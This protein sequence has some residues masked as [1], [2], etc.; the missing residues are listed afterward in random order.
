MRRMLT[1]IVL[2]TL[3]LAGAALSAQSAYGQSAQDFTDW[4]ASAG[5]VATGTLQG[6]AITL[7]GTNV[8]PFPSS[9]LDGS[10]LVFSGPNFTPPLP[11]SDAIQINGATGNAYTLQFATA[12]TDPVIHF[13]SIAS[14]IHFAPG[15]VVTRLSGDAEFSVAG[16]DVVG[17]PDPINPT[18]DA[19][20]SVR[21]SGTFTSIPVTTTFAF[22]D[23]IFV[24]VGAAPPAPPAPPPPPPPPAVAPDFTLAFGGGANEFSTLSVAP[25]G[26][27]SLPVIATRNATS[28]GTIALAVTGL[29]DGITA[30]FV[31]QALDGVSDTATLTISAPASSAGFLGTITITATPQTATAGPTA[32]SLNIDLLVQTALSARV[33]GIE[34]TQ[35]VQ[36]HNQ[37]R[38]TNYNGVSLVKHKKTVVRVFADLVGQAFRG[39]AANRPGMGMAL[40]GTDA[41]GRPL[42]GSPLF[43]EYAPSSQG[44][45]INDSGFSDA[46]RNSSTGPFTFVLPDGWTLGSLNLRASALAAA[47]DTLTTE[48][49]SRVGSVLC[50]QVACGARSAE[51][52]LNGVTFRDPPPAASISALHLLVA[53]HN[54]PGDTTGTVTSITSVTA[55]VEKVFEKLM[56]LSPVPFHF[57]DNRDFGSDWPRYRALR[58]ASDAAI[59]E[60]A[61]AFDADIG[62]PGLGTVGVYNVGLVNGG[63]TTGHTSVVNGATLPVAGSPLWRPTTSVAHEVFHLLGFAHASSECGAGAPPQSV[64]WPV[65]Q[66]RMDS[67]GIDTTPGSDRFGGPYRIIAD[68]ATSPAYDLMSYCGIVSGDAP[69]W[70]SA[71]NWQ[72]A[73]GETPPEQ[74]PIKALGRV[75]PA[76]V[77][78]AITLPSQQSINVLR[79]TSFAG[80]AAAP[81]GFTLLARNSAGNVVSSTP[82]GVLASAAAAGDDPNVPVLEAQ[83][84][85]TG[86]ARV[87]V[88]DASGAVVVSRSASAAAPVASIVSPRRGAKLGTGAETTVRWKVSDA[89]RDATEV[90]LDFS[91]DGG[92]SFY[93]VW[94]GPGSQSSARVPTEL[95]RSAPN[96]RLRLRVSDGFN[97][98]VVTSGRITVVPRRPT[99]QILEPSTRVPVDAG[100]TL[101]LRGAAA[102]ARGIAISSRRLVWRAGGKVLGRGASITAAL[103]AGARSI[104]LEATDR[105]GRTG[106]DSIAVRVRATAPYF[107]RLVAP[108]IARAA[109]SAVLTVAAT[110]P[111]T[112]RVG[113]RRF[114]VG[115]RARKVRVPVGAGKAPRLVLTLSAGGRRSQNT[116]VI[117]RR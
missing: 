25:G 100:G 13:A 3:A 85:P 6:S 77:I 17:G 50:V 112:L 83:I 74:R 76:I 55:P 113:G 59:W 107:V 48:G 16:A 108:T 37:P 86:V 94:S 93:N 64:P 91:D 65:A 32:R 44:M 92:R 43:A 12:V 56:A 104:R 36:T 109:R 18:D 78:Q 47:N 52:L 54:P 66:G 53:F 2:A 42:P 51:R 102:D 24:Q 34:I 23:G 63:V 111:S 95:L 69:H 29:P 26:Q 79:T 105:G 106:A 88:V 75:K 39:A 101:R 5:N 98:T 20:G 81:S 7:S 99:V 22:A 40:F 89:D 21:L 72:V 15:T 87:E 33:E 46:E 45:P 115:T 8:S 114:A 1:T 60:P 35:A 4:T 82:M 38:F 97:E 41:S 9:T 117:K 49:E 58:F 110:Q 30:S 96:A 116:I 71:H 27:S 80:P 28:N 19:N 103:P 11:A 14:V 10:S 68:T 84:D 62:R 61:D 70:I 57:L 90:V 73:L 67:V 31:P